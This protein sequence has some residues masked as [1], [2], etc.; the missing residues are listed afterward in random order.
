MQETLHDHH[1]SISIG[2]WPICNNIDCSSNVELQD[3]T[4]RLIDRATAY[5]MEVSTENS[6]IMT[7]SMSNTCADTG[8]NGQKLNEVTS[9]KYLGTALCKDV[10][11]SAEV[12]IRTASAMAAMVRLNRISASLA[13]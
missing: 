11:Y 2:G 7:N 6:K 8:M 10:T 9:F 5:G 13:S 4:N 3:L 12:H 1:T